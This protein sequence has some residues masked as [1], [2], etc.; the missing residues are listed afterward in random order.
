MDGVVRVI[1]SSP[2]GEEGDTVCS[3]C[4]TVKTRRSKKNSDTPSLSKAMVS[5]CD[6]FSKP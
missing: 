4:C 3:S 5:V 1:G 2:F 6:V